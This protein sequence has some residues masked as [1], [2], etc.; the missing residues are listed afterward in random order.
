M[1][2][3]AQPNAGWKER[4]TALSMD[5]LHK[6]GQCPS[7]GSSVER[8]RVARGYSPDRKECWLME[9]VGTPGKWVSLLPEFAAGVSF[10]FVKRTMERRNTGY[11]FVV[12]LHRAR[13]DA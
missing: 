11:P 8:V 13:A 6:L 4:K 1:A 5:K 2:T 10:S 12:R 3:Q 9:A 7:C